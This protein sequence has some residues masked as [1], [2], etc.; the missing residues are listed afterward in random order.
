MS[1][2]QTFPLSGESPAPTLY[3]KN[4]YQSRCRVRR[5]RINQTAYAYSLHAGACKTDTCPEKRSRYR[6][7]KVKIPAHYL[8]VFAAHRRAKPIPALKRKDYRTLPARF[9][10]PAAPRF[11]ARR[12]APGI[13]DSRNEP[14][15]ALKRKDYRTLPTRFT[16]R[17]HAPGICDSRNEPI[18]ALHSKDNRTLPTRFAARRPVLSFFRWSES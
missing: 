12:P 2:A 10:V 17:W 9:G 15:P 16:A 11:G 18:P 13:C 3:S 4:F 8:R 14:I 7:Y 6:P 1:A 5:G